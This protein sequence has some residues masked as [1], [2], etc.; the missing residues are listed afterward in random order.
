MTIDVYTTA[1]RIDLSLNGTP[2]G[3]RPASRATKFIASFEVPWAPGTLRAVGFDDEGRDVGATELVTAGEPASLSAAADRPSIRASRNDLAYVTVEVVD[4][5]GRRVP[6]AAR[7]LRF[8]V[9]GPADLAGHA[10]GNPA[11]ASSYRGY[12]RTTFDGRA[13]AVLRPTGQPGTIEL[14]VESPGLTRAA[15]NVEAR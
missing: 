8:S 13:I 14:L 15:V 2:V 4:A 1:A 12:L 7:P 10:S 6:D 5:A 11:D 9:I 3:S